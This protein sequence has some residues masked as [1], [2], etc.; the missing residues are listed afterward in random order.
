MAIMKRYVKITG[1]A[2]SPKKQK[3]PDI[4]GKML[5]PKK[6]T[7]KPGVKVLMP[8]RSTDKHSVRVNM[9]G[10]PLVRKY[11]PKLE[12]GIKETRR[13]PGGPKPKGPSKATPLKPQPPTFDRPVRP[14]P[15]RKGTPLKKKMF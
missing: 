1:S 10:K 13:S 15:K 7:D 2:T 9:G 6:S 4:T 14:L 3:K 8:K 11:N 12:P 5:M